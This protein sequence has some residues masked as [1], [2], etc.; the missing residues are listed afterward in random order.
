MTMGRWLE[1]HSWNGIMAMAAPRMTA[2]NPLQG[3]PTAL[4]GSVFPYGFYCVL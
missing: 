4:E 3:K 2:G 1:R